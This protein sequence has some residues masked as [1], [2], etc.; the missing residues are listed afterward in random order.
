M[1][2]FVCQWE[3]E[4]LGVRTDAPHEH[5]ASCKG[6]EMKDRQGFTWC[7][8]PLLRLIPHYMDS[9]SVTLIMQYHGA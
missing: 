4:K 6:E 8:A 1:F 5:L 2:I 9:V 7:I 3:C